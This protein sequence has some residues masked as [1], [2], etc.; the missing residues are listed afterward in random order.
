ME[1]HSLMWGFA[2]RFHSLSAKACWWYQLKTVRI[3][4]PAGVSRVINWYEILTRVPVT[5]IWKC[6]LHSTH[7]HLWTLNISICSA[8]F[9]KKKKLFTE[10]RV[11]MPAAA[12]QPN[13]IILSRS[14][15]L[16]MASMQHT[17]CTIACKMKRPTKLMR[18]ID[19]LFHSIFVFVCFR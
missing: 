8:N 7:F 9:M 2:R 6:S 1:C 4:I 13:D 17:A 16:F 12:Y 14:V 5:L 19:C 10:S 15:C 18:W 11:N 3:T